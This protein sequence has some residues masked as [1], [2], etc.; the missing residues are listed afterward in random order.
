[1]IARCATDKRCCY[2][3]SW[4]ECRRKNSTITEQYLKSQS[5]NDNVDF[6]FTILNTG[7]HAA[8]LPINKKPATGAGFWGYNNTGELIV[9]MTAY[10]V[11]MAMSQLF[12]GGIAY[13]YH[14]Q[15]KVEIFTC[16]RVI[17]VDIHIEFTDF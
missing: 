17:A 14:F 6:R 7:E 9:V 15:F 5:K 16:E 2:S 1:M 10:A 4:G 8:K 12:V 3:E 11:S 13:F